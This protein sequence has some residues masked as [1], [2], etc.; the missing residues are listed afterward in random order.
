MERNT[1]LKTD[2]I[3]KGKDKR[4]IINEFYCLS[5]ERHRKPIICGDC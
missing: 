1:R 5:T 4:H 2:K 3:T